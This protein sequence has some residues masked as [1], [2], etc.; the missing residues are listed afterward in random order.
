[1][2]FWSKSEIVT[3]NKASDGGDEGGEIMVMWRSRW[4]Q[5]IFRKQNEQDLTRG[6]GGLEEAQV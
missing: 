4:R 2:Y 5:E 6:L 3:Q 1:M